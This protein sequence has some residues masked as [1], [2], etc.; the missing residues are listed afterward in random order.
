MKET[1][2]CNKQEPCYFS[3]RQ[4]QL[5]KHTPTEV[6]QLAY[7]V[8]MLERSCNPT[9]SPDQ[10]LTSRRFE[11]VK[12]F[13]EEV[14]KI[15]PLESVF[16]A[17]A[18][19]DKE[20][21]LTCGRALQDTDMSFPHSQM[22]V[23]GAQKAAKR[24]R[25][26]MT[27]EEYADKVKV[28]QQ[29]M[30]LSVPVEMPNVLDLSL[31]MAQHWEQYVQA[32]RPNLGR[33]TA[34][35]FGARGA[36]INGRESAAAN[37]SAFLDGQNRV[38]T[39]AGTGIMYA[40]TAQARPSVSPSQQ[41]TIPILPVPYPVPALPSVPLD[42]DLAVYLDTLAMKILTKAYDPSC[43]LPVISKRTIEHFCPFSTT[44]STVA[45]TK[46]QSPIQALKYARDY[47]IELVAKSSEPDMNVD[48]TTL[49]VNT[50][51][52]R[53][54]RDIRDR[55]LKTCASL[56]A[57]FMEQ[58]I[59]IPMLKTNIDT[60]KVLSATQAPVAMGAWAFISMGYEEILRT[61]L[62]SEGS[63]LLIEIEDYI[64][65]ILETSSAAPKEKHKKKTKKHHP[66]R[67]YAAKLA[68]LVGGIK[69]SR[70]VT[71]STQY[72]SYS[73]EHQLHKLSEQL[74]P[75]LDK[76]CSVKSLVI[77]W[78]RLFKDNALS[79]V[80]QS[81]RPLIARWLKWALNIY[82]LRETLAKY[83]CLGVI[84]LSNSGKSLLVNTLFKLQVT[85][86][87]T[88]IM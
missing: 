56:L 3:L 78:D 20:T 27:D 83:T 22:M 46:L 18:Y 31:G 50:S 52:L 23:L 12:E 30:A 85:T 59:R 63:S 7:C 80:H 54:V 87:Y 45:K 19:G 64:T 13:L 79:L 48:D 41:E 75:Q 82:D 9:S 25:S 84:G 8:A 10:P 88:K 16:Y 76:S 26:G 2:L 38:Q 74:K 28:T 40:D 53:V 39:P 4:I 69:T 62:T 17:I 57:A 60:A 67:N 35:T 66:D 72:I 42:Y 21:A 70:T 58:Q 32:A 68:F 51:M 5:A 11:K 61:M 36:T 73:L 33:G 34:N 65:G 37:H 47:L 14:A 86:N 77:E 43:S 71:S 44:R 6:I 15:V 49:A 1:Q 29:R 24:V 55:N 81:H